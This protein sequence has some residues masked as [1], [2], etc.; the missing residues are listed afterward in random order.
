M[1]LQIFNISHSFFEKC[2]KL[3]FRPG[4]H[5]IGNTA[6]SWRDREKQYRIRIQ[7][8]KISKD[9]LVSSNSQKKGQIL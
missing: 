9:L 3:I 7:R 1:A 8:P 4:N 2:E 5:E 6:K